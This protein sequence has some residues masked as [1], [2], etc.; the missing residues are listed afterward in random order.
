MPSCDDDPSWAKGKSRYKDGSGKYVGSACDKN[1]GSS[2][3]C[4]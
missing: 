4:W 1:K 2:R 3:Q